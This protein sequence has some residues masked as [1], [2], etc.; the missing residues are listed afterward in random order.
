MGPD[1]N[2]VILGH[3]G[4]F[5]I[6][7]EA[8]IRIRPIPEAQNFASIIFPNFEIGQ[9]FMEEMSKQKIYPSSIRLVDNI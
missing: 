7:T 1:Y 4:N 3:E 9:K 5:G 2:Q 8:I 6:V